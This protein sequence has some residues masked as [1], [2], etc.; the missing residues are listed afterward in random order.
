M[1]RTRGFSLVE[2]AV[3]MTVVAL[4]LGGLMYTLSAQTEQRNFEDTRRRLEIA[5][6]LVLSYAIVKG[7]L[8]CPARYTSSASHSQ[9]LESFCTS[10]ATSSVSTCSGSETTTEQ[11]HGTCSNH[12]DGYL[13]AATIGFTQVDANGFAIDVWGNR[14][15]YAVSRK[16]ASGTCGTAP[17]NTYTTIFTS[18]SYLQTYGVACQ[19]DD[20]EIC[21]SASG[22]TGA[23]TAAASCGSA[24]NRIMSQSLVVALVFST[25]RMQIPARV[26]TRPPISTLIGSTSTTS[27][28]RPM[29]RPASSTIS[30]PGSRLA[31]S[32][33]G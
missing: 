11:S 9:G 19:P 26:R 7:R 5:R 32:L 12:F 6:E 3:V 10:A 25:A 29:R 23:G 16:T 14:I 31:S 27:R 33:A 13:P 24:A 15:R 17:P 21:K 2:L 20:I 4:L 8:P 1:R 18:K 22:I 30:S 28:G